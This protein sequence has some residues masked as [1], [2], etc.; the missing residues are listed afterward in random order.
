MDSNILIGGDINFTL[1]H[2]ELWGTSAR[3]G[4]LPKYFFNELERIGSIDIEPVEI[5][6]TWVDNRVGVYFVE[7]R[8][9]KF[10]LHSQIL[11]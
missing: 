9:D 2:A 7:K 5:K 1:N 4:P 10:L 3:P 11:Q 8:L 6:P